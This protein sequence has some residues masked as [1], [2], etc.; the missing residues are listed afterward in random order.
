MS[1]PPLSI[2]ETLQ[3]AL[4]LA[5]SDKFVA[6]EAMASW[7]KR[8]V[9]STNDLRKLA[10]VYAYS[11][12][13]LD[14]EGV[15]AIVCARHDVGPADCYMLA[16]VQFALGRCDQAICNFQRE[17][18]SAESQG[19]RICLDVAGIN[20]AYL[21]AAAGKTPSALQILRRL[22]GLQRAHVHGVG[23]LTKQALL[24]RLDAR[25]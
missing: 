14:A 11:G 25:R 10:L 3:S 7:L 6:A 23:F 12:S 8:D 16:S 5:R 17:V 18:D 22:D 1:R 24:A 15:W 19:R 4:E 2:P 21:L 20:L 13:N 9:L